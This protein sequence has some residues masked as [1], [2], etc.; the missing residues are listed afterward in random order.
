MKKE[1]RFYI[2][3]LIIVTTGVLI[4]LFL[5]NL[6]ENNQAQKYY[7]ASI[8]T[9]NTE[10]EANYTELSEVIEKQM[11]LYDTLIKYNDTAIGIGEIVMKSGGLIGTELSNAGLDLY[12][13]N[14]ISSIDFELMSVLNEMNSSS[15][16]MNDKLDRLVDFVYLKILD[17]TK[18]SKFVF[19]IL[20]QDAIGTENSLLKLYKDYID[21]NIKL[22]NNK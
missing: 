2:I 13:R 20:I 19:S 14:Q 8:V 6:K 7:E 17:N 3:E 12:K 22:E 4:A 5:G 10:I 16:I 11:S 9:I 15:K 18:E 1:I 21:K